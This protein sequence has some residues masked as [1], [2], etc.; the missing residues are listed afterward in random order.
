MPTVSTASISQSMEGHSSWILE[1][2]L[3]AICYVIFLL[4]PT[5]LT[6]KVSH[7]VTVANKSKVAYEGVD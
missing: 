1:L 3:Q 2:V 4:F 6:P 7:L 5:F